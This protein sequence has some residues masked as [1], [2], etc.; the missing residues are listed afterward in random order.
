MTIDTAVHHLLNTVIT[1]NTPSL[2][3]LDNELLV[4]CG[5]LLSVES[6]CQPLQSGSQQQLTVLHQSLNTHMSQAH[7]AMT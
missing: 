3:L 1:A 2:H 7:F 4:S 6:C 5:W